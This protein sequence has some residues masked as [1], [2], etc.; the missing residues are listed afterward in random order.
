M[1]ED[2]IDYN[3]KTQTFPFKKY[4]QISFYINNDWHFYISDIIRYAVNHLYGY[5]KRKLFMYD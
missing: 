2:K 5:P 3:Y 4:V 1:F